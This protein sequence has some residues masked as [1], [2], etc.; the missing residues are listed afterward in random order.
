MP[1]IS[2]ILM[3]EIW[4]PLRIS[5]PFFLVRLVCIQ[6]EYGYLLDQISGFCPNMEKYP[7]LDT[8]H[9]VV[10]WVKSAWDSF[11]TMMQQ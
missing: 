4:N 8:F 7:Y 2:A 5:D 10:K 1:L 11:Y 6:T 9:A 3:L